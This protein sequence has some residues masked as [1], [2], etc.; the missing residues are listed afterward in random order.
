MNWVIGISDGDRW[1]RH[2]GSPVFE[3]LTAALAWASDYLEA[4]PG[5]FGEHDARGFT[6]RQLAPADA[7]KQRRPAIRAEVP[8]ALSDLTQRLAFAP[9]F[10]EIMAHVAFSQQRQR[11]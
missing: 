7:G 2:K 10:R 5:V 4:H 11:A 6:F 9:T 8:A 1:K 3:N